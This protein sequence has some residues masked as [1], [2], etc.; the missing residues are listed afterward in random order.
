MIPFIFLS[1]SF[2]LLLTSDCEFQ[3]G[4][5]E[6]A[7]FFQIPDEIDHE[8]SGIRTLVVTVSDIGAFGKWLSGLVIET[9]FRQ[10]AQLKV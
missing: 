8:R 1:Q 10:L 9:S 4:E 2:G 3:F 5:S 7:H 6:L